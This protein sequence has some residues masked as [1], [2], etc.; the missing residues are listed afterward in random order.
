MDKSV[1]IKRI[2]DIGVIPV[3][4]ASSAEEAIKVVETIKA[5]GVSILEIT[6]TVPGAV[7][8]IE[9]LVKRFGDETLVGVGTV[10]DPE[11]A[12]AC[13]AVGAQFVVTPALNLQTIKFCREQDIPVMPGALT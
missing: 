11:V 6:M 8:V 10:L 12:K 5:G 9:Q 1:V 2:R 13:I 3:V 7:Q 4:R